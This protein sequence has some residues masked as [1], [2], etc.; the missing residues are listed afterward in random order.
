MGGEYIP[1]WEYVKRRFQEENS[2]QRTQRAQRILEI[3]FLRE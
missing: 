2:P 3:P 1:I